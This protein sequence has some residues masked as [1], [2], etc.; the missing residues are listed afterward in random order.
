MKHGIQ[1]N[2]IGNKIEGEIHKLSQ[3]QVLLYN[4]S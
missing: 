4:L 3:K 2:I 1:E